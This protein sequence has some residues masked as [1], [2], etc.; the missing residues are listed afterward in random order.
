[1]GTAIAAGLWTAT[2]PP[3]LLGGRHRGTGQI[4]FPNPQGAAGDDF[5]AMPLHRTG[6][7]WSFTVQRFAPKSPPYA[8]PES[9]EPFAVGYVELADQIIVESRLDTTDFAALRIG[10]AVEFTLV[11]FGDR[12]TFAFRPR[13][14]VR[15]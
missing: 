11:P 14:E 5:D 13:L 12:V 1:M 15:P 6:T 7:L 4:V 2:D 3:A 8:G 10:M 9:F